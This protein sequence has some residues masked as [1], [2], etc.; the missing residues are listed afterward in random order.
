VAGPTVL[1]LLGAM[2]GSWLF[3]TLLLRMLR[4]RHPGAFAELG[5]PTSR[6]LASHLPRH[7]NMQI[8]FWKGLW[9][10]KY[11]RTGDRLVSAIA[12]AAL[13]FDIALVI[14]VVALF[15]VSAG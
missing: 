13:F 14:A 7:R 6:Q 11:F 4:A 12:G 15:R 2:G 3:R 5:Q 8:Q 1:F 9:G 10:G